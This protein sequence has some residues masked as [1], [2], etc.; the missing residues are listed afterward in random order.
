M[1]IIVVLIATILGIIVGYFV[2]KASYEKQLTAAR[3]TA[4]NILQ[5]AQQSAELTLKNAESEK[6]SVL[7]SAKEEIQQY[8]S[9][10]EDEVKQRRR[11][12]VD[13]EKRL[14]QRETTLDR[15]D[16][17]LL[18]REQTIDAKEEALLKRTQVLEEE[19]LKVK[20]LV[21]EQQ[22]ALEK[23]ASLT[24]DEAKDII[25]SDLSQQ[26][27]HERAI[28]VKESE[29]RTKE[30]ADKQAK[31]IILSAMQ[32]AG[33]DLVSENTVSVVSLPSD[34]MKGRIIGRE[35]RNIRTLETLTG[36]D[37]I[38]DDTPEAVVLSGFDPIRREIA[39]MTL[40]KLTKDGRIHPAR[41]EEMVDKSRKEM[42]ERIREIGEKAVFDLGIHT[43]HPD[44]IKIIG[45]LAFR[46]S[47]GQNVLNHSIEVA[48]LSALMASELGEDETIAKRAGLLHDLGKALDHEVEG[49][50]VEIGAEIAKKYK[51]NAI[52][53]NAIASHH[54]DVE[55]TSTIAVIV[56]IAD[57]LSASRPGA[58]SDSLENYIKRLEKLEEISSSFEGIDK[59]FAIQAGREVRVMVK[60]NV[61]DDEQTALLARDIKQKIET[62]LEY[63]GQIKITVI[64]E[65]R[66]VELAK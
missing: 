1:T 15:K 41:I 11:E 29:I 44:L 28:M 61:L 6:K 14:V 35:G 24:R 36:I 30:I 18:R 40:E 45:R 48:R 59:S 5:D 20:A 57:A 21:E 54:G 60:P 37:V 52:V 12:V 46:T 4:Q 7:L 64:R 63:P 16:E 53:V 51:E 27:I 17:N 10:V 66:S 62:E 25:L 58:R 55:V 47:Y 39:K 26:L 34:E 19:E 22:V 50:H 32:R 33:S 42:D 49:T 38:I 23:V 13:Q 43:L 56:A 3:L 65:V 9:N 8:K 2:R 31:D